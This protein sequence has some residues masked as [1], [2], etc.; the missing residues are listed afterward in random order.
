MVAI[1]TYELR[2]RFAPALLVASPWILVAVA[3][4]QTYAAP[5][6]T[7]SV[8]AVIFLV[9][10]YGFSFVVRGLGLKI[11]NG[12]WRSWGGPPSAVILTEND[13]TFPPET[14]SRIKRNLVTELGIPK[15]IET[16]RPTD[17]DRTQDAFRLVRQYLRQR[18]PN[19]VWYTHNA[20][21][22]FLRNLFGSWWLLLI[23]ALV[24]ATVCG[25]LWAT[26][27]G[28][29]LLVLA[30]INA[31]IALIAVATRFLILPSATRIAAFRYAESAWSS[32]LVQTSSGHQNRRGDVNP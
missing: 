1:D 7:T 14:K 31:A 23:N 2:A 27:D 26:T 4:I 11:E 20:E 19:G 30:L 32:F 25:I 17:L 22:G 21:Y 5:L 6:I 3:F 12:L 9:L 10:L 15:D 24:A 8:A 28:Q 13:H 18:D 29:T 16:D